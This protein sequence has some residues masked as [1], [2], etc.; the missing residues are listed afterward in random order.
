VEV[1]E[2]TRGGE[3]GE[4]AE[5]ERPR[6]GEHAQKLPSEKDRQQ[7]EEVVLPRLDRDGDDRRAERPHEGDAGRRHRRPERAAGEPEKRERGHGDDDEVQRRPGDDP[8]PEQQAPAVQNPEVARR[9][10]VVLGEIGRDRPQAARPLRGEEAL[11]GRGGHPSGYGRAVAADDVLVRALVAGRREVGD[12]L[13]VAERHLVMQGERTG[14]RPRQ[15]G[16]DEDR[17]SVSQ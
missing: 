7:G 13:V 2:R 11:P 5:S 17:N 12:C 3:R 1:H 10:D 8:D 4:H 14:A 16:D 9:V 6:P 15:D